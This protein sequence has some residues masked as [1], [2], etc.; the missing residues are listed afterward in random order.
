MTIVLVDSLK[1]GLLTQ[2]PHRL[3]PARSTSQ[4]A[5]PTGSGGFNVYTKGEEERWREGDVL[6]DVQP[7]GGTWARI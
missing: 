4:Q 3:K 2:K 7:S 6:L 1:L 5:P